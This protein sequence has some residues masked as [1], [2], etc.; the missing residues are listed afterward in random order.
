MR[1][2]VRRKIGLR[3][4]LRSLGYTAENEVAGGFTSKIAKILVS[5]TGSVAPPSSTTIGR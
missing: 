4:L 1:A 2:L 5:T 3:S